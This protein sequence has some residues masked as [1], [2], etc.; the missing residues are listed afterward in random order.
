MWSAD[1]IDPALF[2]KQAFIKS[3]DESTTP[4]E[5]F[6]DTLK[7]GHQVL[8]ESFE[9]GISVKDLVP[10]RAWLVDQL[11]IRAWRHKVTSEKISLVSARN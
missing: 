6:K 4:L 3:L 1:V 8:N 10:K 7:Q 5:I 2:D 11:L 9:A